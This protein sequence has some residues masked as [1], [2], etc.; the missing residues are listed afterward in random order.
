MP[1]PGSN[2]VLSV[3]FKVAILRYADAKIYSS[4]YTTKIMFWIAWHLL[5]NIYNCCSVLCEN[6]CLSTTCMF[7]IAPTC[8]CTSMPT[9]PDFPGASRLQTESSGLLYGWPDFPDT[10]EIS[11]T[12]AYSENGCTFA[13]HFAILSRNVGILI[14]SL[15]RANWNPREQVATFNSKLL[16][17]VAKLRLSFCRKKMW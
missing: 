9:L 11:K 15:L 5:K 1:I 7:D 4:G 3:I 12:S 13:R 2:K 14:G 17:Q 16:E 6:N 8:T 10:Y